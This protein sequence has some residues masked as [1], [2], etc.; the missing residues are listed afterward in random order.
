MVK[1]KKTYKKNTRIDSNFNRNLLICIVIFILIFVVVFNFEDMK[2]KMSPDMTGSGYDE[3]SMMWEDELDLESI[4][5]TFI[6]ENYNILNIGSS[7]SIEPSCIPSESIAC[8]SKIDSNTQSY[9]T[10]SGENCAKQIEKLKKWE[11]EYKSLTKKITSCFNIANNFKV[12]CYKTGQASKDNCKRGKNIQKTCETLVKVQEGLEKEKPKINPECMKDLKRVPI[13]E[14]IPYGPPLSLP[15]LD[16]DTCQKIIIIAG[17]AYI[18]WTA[19][20][21]VAA[22]STCGLSLALP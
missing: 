16:E 15:E 2:L 22:P 8:L 5:K 21:I 7:V 6:D 12:F 1:K 11:K 4:D 10:A 13:K 19:C 17:V 9:S 3:G 18:C 20:K 14:P